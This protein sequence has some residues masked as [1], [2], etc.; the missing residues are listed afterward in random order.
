MADIVKKQATEAQTLGIQG[1]PTVLVNGR[2]V[3]GAPSYDSVR[4]VILEE[5]SA[6]PP[7]DALPADQAAAG[8]PKGQ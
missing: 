3:S 6:T 5:L 2:Y 1:T 4:A 8:R 7:P